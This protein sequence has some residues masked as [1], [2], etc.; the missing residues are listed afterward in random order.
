MGTNPESE[1][2]TKFGGDLGGEGGAGAGLVL[3]R[4][5]DQILQKQA[6]CLYHLTEVP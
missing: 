4:P 3:R 2:P 6:V 5:E 1:G